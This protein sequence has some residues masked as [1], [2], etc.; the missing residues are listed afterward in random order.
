M[1]FALHNEWEK[2]NLIQKL[3]LITHVDLSWG[4]I[5]SFTL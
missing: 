5:P 3:V 1:C 4:K 2:D